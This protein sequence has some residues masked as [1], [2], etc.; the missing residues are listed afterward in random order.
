[1]RLNRRDALLAILALPSGAES[2]LVREMQDQN[3]GK[4]SVLSPGIRFVVSLADEDE[5]AKSGGI[6]ELRVNYK[7]QYVKFSAK[8][9]WEAL[10]PEGK[11]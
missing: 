1:M 11:P 7:S 10:T 6:Y 5:A 8:E 2:M 3:G 9:L 4:V